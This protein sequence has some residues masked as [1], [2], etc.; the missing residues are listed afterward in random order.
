LWAHISLSNLPLFQ[1]DAAFISINRS[2]AAK[3]KKMPQQSRA[4][5]G[6]GAKGAESLL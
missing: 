6:R 5:P 1:F 3:S 4:H 2:A